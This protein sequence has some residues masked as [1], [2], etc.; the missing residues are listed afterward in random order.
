MEDD[1]ILKKIKEDPQMGY[2]LL[3]DAFQKPLYFYVRKTVFSHDDANDIMQNVWIKVFQNIE[4]F[5]GDS[6]LSTWLYRIATNETYTFLQKEAKKKK[7]SMEMLSE[8]QA[9]LLAEDSLFTGDEISQMLYKNVARL[10]EKQRQVFQLKY[11]EDKKYE[12]ISEILDTSVGAL[13]AS[14]HHAVQKL[15][16]SIPKE[17]QI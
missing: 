12:E 15:K 16:M 13:K 9:E 2:G 8:S 5:R 4:G 10:P 14:Y 1:K 11:F 7:M 6:Q 3:L 17:I